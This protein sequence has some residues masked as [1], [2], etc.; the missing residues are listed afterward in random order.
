MMESSIYNLTQPEATGLVHYSPTDMQTVELVRLE[1][2]SSSSTASSKSDL[3]T[4]A[5]R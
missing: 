4:P 1:Q 2:P 3:P 5:S